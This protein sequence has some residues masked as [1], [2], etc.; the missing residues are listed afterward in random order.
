MLEG[1]AAH[2]LARAE[3]RGLIERDGLVDRLRA[4]HSC[5]GSHLNYVDSC[6]HC[7]SIDI[8]EERA[9]H[10][11]TCG[12]V[13]EERSFERA[14]RLVCPKC[15]TRLRHIGTDYDRPIEHGIC[16]SCNERFIEAEIHAGCLDCGAVTPQDALKTRTVRSYM[17]GAPGEELARNGRLSSPV[18]TELGKSVGREQ[19]LWTLQWLNASAMSGDGQGMMAR[20]VA[21]GPQDSS[22][23]AQARRDRLDLQIRSLLA[24]TD[25][26]H[27]PK[28]GCT[29]VLFPT[30]GQGR[31]QAFLRE[32]ETLVAAFTSEQTDISIAGYALPEPDVA[33]DAAAWLDAL[34]ASDAG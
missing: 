1:S 5:G 6:P 7:D 34:V 10:C 31:L 23:D 29:L 19:F 24:P 11:F 9:I 16:R 18:E 4:C 2:W 33:S 25:V 21:T 13:A 3:R 27:S 15:Q 22:D 32:V 28:P 14:E 8:E 20:L 30:D 12:H 26:C 17:L